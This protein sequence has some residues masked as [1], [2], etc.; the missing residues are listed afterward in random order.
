MGT[1]II[2]ILRSMATKDLKRFFAALRMTFVG[3]GAFDGPKRL[4]IHRGNGR[5]VNRPYRA[6]IDTFL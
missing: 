4:D 6:R 5:F 1:R 2:V 3:A